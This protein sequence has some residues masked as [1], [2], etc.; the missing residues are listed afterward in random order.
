MG[1]GADVELLAV[2]LHDEAGYRSQLVPT[3]S[4]RARGVERPQCLVDV[5]LGV[6]VSSPPGA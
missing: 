5:P 4:P 2:A 3:P 6:Q 1:R